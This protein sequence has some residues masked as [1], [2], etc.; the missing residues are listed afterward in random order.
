MIVSKAFWK[1]VLKNIGSIILPTVILLMFGTISVT[2][3]DSTAQYEARK[4]ALVIFNHDENVGLTKNF[5][6]YLE[7]NATIKTGYED[8]DRLKDALFYEEVT[9]VVEIPENF[10]QDM[11][12]G[13]DP[14][15][16]MRSSAG[17]VA[18]LAKVAVRRY[19]SVAK[20]YSA[21]H[22]SEQELVAKVDKAIANDVKTEM[23]AAVDTSKYAKASRYYSFANYT[24]LSCFITIICLIM[25]AFNRE[26]VR[27]RNLVGAIDIKK[28]NRILLRNCCIYALAAWAFYVVISVFV[29][30]A[31]VVFTAQGA[32]Y[33]A[34]SLVFAACATTIAYL[35]SIFALSAGAVNG[36]QNV[37]ALG[38]SFL[39]GAFVPAEYLPDSVLA[40]AHVLPSY[41]YIDVNDKIM[42]IQQFDATTMVPIL[43]EIAVVAGFCVLFVALANIISKKRQRIA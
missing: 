4:P 15:V 9:A 20:G 13:H 37:L 39:C 5:I 14:E 30:G 21:L 35:I 25:S 6:E 32:L 41:Y 42:K 36:L 7:E 31:E 43:L 26:Q 34:N 17:Y 29:L 19:L 11:A 28:M 16:K 33:A 27:K 2:S 40:F 24:I 38:T 23:K 1:I 10:H 22:L 12:L 3:V 18:E 8:D